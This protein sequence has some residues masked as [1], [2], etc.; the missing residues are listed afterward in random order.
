MKLFNKFEIRALPK[1][2]DTLPKILNNYSLFT[3]TANATVLACKSMI[4][5]SVSTLPVNLFFRKN[6]GERIK[7]YN[8]SLFYLLKYKPNFEEPSSMFLSRLFNDL[9]ESGNA[10]I[11]KQF[12][13]N[14]N[15][16][17]LYLLSAKYMTVTRDTFT[18]QKIFTYNGNK[19]NS[20]QILHIPGKYYD[21]TIGKEFNCKR[22]N[23]FSE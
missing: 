6:D 15:I 1:T 18:N 10:Y 2:K 20:D 12:D 5:D 3:N 4:I 21:G 13:D 8:H 16:I 7:A 19:Y 22:C 9:L 14:Y 23:I 11:Y 17:A